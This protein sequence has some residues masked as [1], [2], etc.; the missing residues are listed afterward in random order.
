MKYDSD[1]ARIQATRKELERIQKEDV[2]AVIAAEKR[3]AEQA[4]AA[5]QQALK[6]STAKILSDLED[7]LRN[8]ADRVR[9][10]DFLPDGT[11]KWETVAEWRDKEG[12][13]L[14]TSEGY[15]PLEQIRSLRDRVVSQQRLLEALPQADRDTV[16]TGYKLLR[17]KFEGARPYQDFLRS[18]LLGE[19][20]ADLKQNP[21]TSPRRP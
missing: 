20:F 5:S 13:T 19:R 4:L 6:E 8:P 16:L 18:Q 3:K 2:P 9:E 7:P 1:L 11:P 17:D 12:H 14:Y 15:L 10:I 21:Q